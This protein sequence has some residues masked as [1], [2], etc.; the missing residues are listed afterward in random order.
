MTAYAIEAE[1]RAERANAYADGAEMAMAHLF[2]AL[3][4]GKDMET[5]WGYARAMIESASSAINSGT[6]SRAERRE[7][8]ETIR[9]QW[10]VRCNSIMADVADHKLAP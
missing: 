4:S 6:A 9:E 3:T 2:D 8:R 7:A 1:I 10:G 5:A